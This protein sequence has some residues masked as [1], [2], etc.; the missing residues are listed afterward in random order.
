MSILN[1]A[2][3]KSYIGIY[4]YASANGVNDNL[5]ITNNSVGSATATDYI[6]HDGIMVSQGTGGNISKN[7]VYNI[8]VNAATV[9]GIN[10]QAGFINAVISK[11]IL[12]NITATGTGGY[13]GR[14]IY[15]N[16]GTPTSNL[17]I[18]N[19]IINTIGGDGYTS[20]SASSPVGM[21]FDGI[22]GGVNI[23]YNSVSMTGTLTY[24]GKTLST[25]IYFS[26]VGIT[27]VDLRNNTFLNSMNNT[28]TGS[29]AKNYAI[30]A[31]CPA[32]SLSI[33]I[34]IITLLAAPRVSLVI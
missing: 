1:N 11:N 16:T 31:N 2:V 33:L 23:Y 8:V 28:A 5:V 6:G 10:I 12:T 14:G 4:A 20:F 32:A 15:V 30:Y 3:S 19:N 7:Y 34:I 21:Y 13:G 25:G 22:T 18:S 9:S 26:G 29:T 27:G 17:A 24:A